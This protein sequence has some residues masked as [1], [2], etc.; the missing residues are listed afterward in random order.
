[1]FSG[2]GGFDLAMRNLG[3]EIVG[4]C[5]IDKYARQIYAKQFPGVPI[6]NDAT[7]LQG[8]TLPQFDVLWRWIPL[9]SFQHCWEKERIQ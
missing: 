8:D 6:H 7:A 5:E 1:M 2:I 3:H 9:S 4:A